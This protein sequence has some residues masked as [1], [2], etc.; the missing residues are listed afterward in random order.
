MVL[1]K[2][3]LLLNSYNPRLWEGLTGHNQIKRLYFI[4]PI[5][6]FQPFLEEKKKKTQLFLEYP[7]TNFLFL[8]QYLVDLCISPHNPT[9]WI[10]FYFLYILK[11]PGFYISWTKTLW[12]IFF[13]IFKLTCC[14]TNEAGIHERRIL[15]LNIY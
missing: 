9:L 3:S 11:I 5:S 4:Y 10:S 1:C 14:I 12:S 2:N 8:L 13:F 15:T 6:S 7:I